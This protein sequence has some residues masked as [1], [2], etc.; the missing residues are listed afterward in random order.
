[1]FRLRLNEGSRCRGRTP[2]ASPVFARTVCA[3]SQA[4]H[5][6]R[7]HDHN[8]GRSKSLKQIKILH[9]LFALYLIVVCEAVM[10]K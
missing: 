10:S 4:L 6:F 7:L 1:M 8:I 9:V 2:G 5:I 3:Y